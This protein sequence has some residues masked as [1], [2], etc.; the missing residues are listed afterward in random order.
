MY[1]IVTLVQ[2][3]YLR[4]VKEERVEQVGDGDGGG[5]GLNRSV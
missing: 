3:L 5:G 1:H 4:I 2:Q